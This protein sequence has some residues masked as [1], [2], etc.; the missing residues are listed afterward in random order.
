MFHIMA[1]IVSRVSSQTVSAERQSE[2]K[3][4]ARLQRSWIPFIADTIF[5]LQQHPSA[6]SAKQTFVSSAA[7]DRFEPKLPNATPKT[8]VRLLVG[9]GRGHSVASAS[10]AHLLK[11]SAAASV[12]AFTASGL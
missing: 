6:L 7:N 12:D 5:L 8:N 9:A 10:L 2:G 1:N 4:D 3:C 11:N